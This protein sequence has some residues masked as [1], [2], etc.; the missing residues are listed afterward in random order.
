MELP[1][2]ISFGSLFATILT[3][4]VFPFVERPMLGYDDIK[5]SVT[6]NNLRQYVLD[7]KNM[8]FVKLTNVLVSL[9]VPINSMV[10]QPYLTN[11]VLTSDLNISNSLFKINVLPPQAT[12][13]FTMQTNLSQPDSASNYIAAEEWI[14]YPSW[15]IFL[16]NIIAF[17]VAGV[18][19]FYTIR[20]LRKY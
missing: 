17:V 9:N 2:A 14:G 3:G 1:D 8:G 16:T 11:S 7:V 15:Y 19:I 4:I 18:M 10:S 5:Q 6:S 13:S 12:I 20:I